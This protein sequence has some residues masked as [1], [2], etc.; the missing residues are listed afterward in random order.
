MCRAAST[1]FWLISCASLYAQNCKIQ[2][3]P[4]L[5][6][7]EQAGWRVQITDGSVG[8]YSLQTGDLLTSIDGHGARHVGPLAVADAFHDTDASDRAVPLTVQRGTQRMR[9]SLWTSDDP[10][11]SVIAKPPKKRYLSNGPKAPDFTLRA[12][13]DAS[14]KLGSERGKWVLVSF[15]ATWC[16]PCMQ[17]AAAL[18]RLA[19]AYPRRLAVLALALKDSREELNAF[20]TKVEPVYTILDAGPLNAKPALSYGVGNSKGGGHIPVNILVRPDGMI[21]Y[22]LFGYEEPSPL[23]KEVGDAIAAKQ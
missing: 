16:A 6:T 7:R 14:V 19:R 21:T 20:S 9:V 1:I 22:V 17:E 4:F 12:L 8:K 2:D 5:L 23:E 13:N 15:W 11:P 3:S 18:N 10:Q